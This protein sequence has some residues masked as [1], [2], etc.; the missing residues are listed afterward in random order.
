MSVVQEIPSST[1]GDVPASQ[2]FT[3]EQVSA[4]LQYNV[5]SQTAFTVVWVIT[6]FVSSQ[7]SVVHAILSST[8]GGVPA[9][10]YPVAL[11]T[12]ASLQ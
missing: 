5:S 1:V 12:S 10:Q 7:V 2:P 11:Q 3:A 6:S 8:V 4:P 9:S